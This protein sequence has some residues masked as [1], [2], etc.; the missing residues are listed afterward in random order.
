[1][2]K[3]LTVTGFEDRPGINAADNRL[4]IAVD[5]IEKAQAVVSGPNAGRAW[6]CRAGLEPPGCA[7][8]A[9]S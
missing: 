2:A 1:V 3:D 8:L 5:D 6:E 7:H 4:V 9:D